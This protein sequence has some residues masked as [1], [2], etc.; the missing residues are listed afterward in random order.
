MAS[1]DRDA[2]Q[3]LPP[4]EQAFFVRESPGALARRDDAWLQRRRLAWIDWI[5]TGSVGVVG[6]RLLGWDAAVAALVFLAGFWLGV[7]ADAILW[8]LRRRS[9]AE[10]Q[11]RDVDDRAVWAIVDAL[12]GRTRSP[13]PVR[14]SPAFGFALA[15]DAVAGLVA[16]ALF[17]RGS[18]AAGIDMEATL[19][20]GAFATGVALVAAGLLPS[21]VARLRARADENALPPFQAGQRGIGLLVLVFGLMAMGGGSL[22][23]TRLL[24]AAFAFVAVTGAIELAFGVPRERAA[25]EWLRR[26]REGGRAGAA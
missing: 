23:A 6:L 11:A 17:V 12:R 4:T 26:E 3:R 13:A 14:G 5:V 16:T 1:I 22:T 21:L 24:T 8:A 7:I 15:V 20:E 9:I 2:W 19:R 25:A 10:A 18:T